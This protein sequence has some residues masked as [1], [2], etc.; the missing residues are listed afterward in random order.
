MKY[1]IQNSIDGR[2]LYK[3]KSFD[4]YYV[5][6]LDTCSNDLMLFVTDD[7]V[8]AQE[9]LELIKT[10]WSGINVEGWKIIEL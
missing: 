2:T 8:V 7:K 4:R 3:H 9:L 10:R 6:D 5:S 1:R